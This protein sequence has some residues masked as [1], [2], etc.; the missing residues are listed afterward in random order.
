MTGDL[1]D[2]SGRRR[3]DPATKTA[4]TTNRKVASMLSP[5]TAH[6]VAYMVRQDPELVR[7][8]AEHRR[9]R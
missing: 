2:A 3:R 4:A 9:T 6:F 7:V 1:G 5:V 8:R